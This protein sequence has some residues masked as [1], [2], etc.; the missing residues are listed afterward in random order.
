MYEPAWFPEKTAAAVSEA[1]GLLTALAGLLFL[2]L[3]PARR[4]GRQPKAA[5]GPSVRIGLRYAT[6]AVPRGGGR[7]CRAEF[8]EGRVGVGEAEWVDGCGGADECLRR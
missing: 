6:Q 4:R 2:A 5:A 8:V 1:A 7:R 3:R